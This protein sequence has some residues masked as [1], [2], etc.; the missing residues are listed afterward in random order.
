M[1]VYAPSADDREGYLSELVSTNAFTTRGLYLTSA[2]GRMRARSTKR[3]EALAELVGSTAAMGPGDDIVD[4]G[5]GF[6]A[7]DAFWMEHFA[8]R[9]ITD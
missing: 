9:R 5:L 7:Q 1:G 4:V 3:G 8:P 2:I 6:A